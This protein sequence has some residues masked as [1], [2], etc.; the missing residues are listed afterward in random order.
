MLLLFCLAHLQSGLYAWRTPPADRQT[1]CVLLRETKL[2]PKSL[3]EES[4][5]S[6]VPRHKHG[7]G[8]GNVGLN[9]SHWL[10]LWQQIEP[11]LLQNANSTAARERETGVCQALGI[12]ADP[13]LLMGSCQPGTVQWSISH[14]SETALSHWLRESPVFI[15]RWKHWVT[16]VSC[17][18]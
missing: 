16:Q 13:I 11:I 9:I 1:L 5:C 17:N 14:W 15:G 12:A 18:F 7:L 4:N 2:N 10:S 6:A 8:R 3:L